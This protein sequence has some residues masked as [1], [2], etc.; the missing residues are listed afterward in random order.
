MLCCVILSLSLRIILH[1]THRRV[2]RRDGG[3]RQIPNRGQEVGARRAE[4]QVRSNGR[5]G[6]D[7][8]VADALKRGDITA[9]EAQKARYDIALKVKSSYHPGYV[10]PLELGGADFLCVCLSYFGGWRSPGG[11]DAQGGAHGRQRADPLT[12]GEAALSYMRIRV[13]LAF[14][15]HTRGGG[16]SQAVALMLALRVSFLLTSR[17]KSILSLREQS[18]RIALEQVRD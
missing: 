10:R 1:L 18:A 16:G 14:Q 8:G 2:L 11:G 5:A 9:R 4:R 7:N 3:G 6:P 15:M 13:I 17:L 12:R